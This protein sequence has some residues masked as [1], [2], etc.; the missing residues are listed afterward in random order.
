M[1]IYIYIIRTTAARH[2]TLEAAILALFGGGG[3]GDGVELT[4]AEV[5][6]AGRVRL[7]RPL[8]MITTAGF[9][10]ARPAP[11]CPAPPRHASPRF[12]R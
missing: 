5:V 7:K 9:R 10:P 6:V 11:P 3:S 8:R 12:H 4:R 1:Y 2:L